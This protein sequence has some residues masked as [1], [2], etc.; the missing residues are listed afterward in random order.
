MADLVSVAMAIYN[1]KRYLKEQ[2][3]SIL[4]QSH[5][6]IELVI[7]DDASTDGS[8]ELASEIASHDSRIRL[9]R[10]EH[11]LGYAANFIKA[12]SLTKGPS[13]AFADQDDV[14]RPEKIE[15]LLKLLNE[16]PENRLAYSDLE[17]VDERLN[18][19][20]RSFWREA[21]IR[22]LSGRPDERIFLRNPAPGCSMLFRGDIRDRFVGLPVP[23]PFMH[24]HLAFI[25]A[26]GLGRV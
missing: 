18:R 25:L 12:L 11:N 7:V 23:M 19:T 16:N 5:R 10:N 4:G 22:P 14:W 17:V 24:D 1:G 3:D 9:E 8:Y 26:A 21:G 13:A 20:H 2:I 15:T 6:H